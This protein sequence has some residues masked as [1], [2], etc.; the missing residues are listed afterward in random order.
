MSFLG[1]ML[2]GI[3]VKWTGRLEWWEKSDPEKVLKGMMQTMT[4]EE[5]KKS[6][7]WV[8]RGICFAKISYRIL[9]IGLFFQFVGAVLK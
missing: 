7:K 1:V 9:P 8:N 6:G 3:G 4:I 2:L 5:L